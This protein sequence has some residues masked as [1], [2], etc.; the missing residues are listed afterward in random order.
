VKRWCKLAIAFAIVTFSACSEPVE[1][2]PDAAVYS[3]IVT[4]APNLTE[5]VFA[6][7]AGDAL[8]GV[9]AYSDY[10]PE[11]AS[12]P[13]VGDAFVIDQERLALLQ[14][15]LLLV[16]QSG[17][18]R[19]VVQE[20]RGLGY[21]VETLRTRSLDDV[22]AALR[23][24]GELTAHA[25]TARAAAA[26]FARTLQSIAV[27]NEGLERL[28]VFYQVSARPLYTING[29]HFVSQLIDLC[30]GDN[31]F[32]DLG[33]LAPAVDVEAVIARDPEV[34]LASTDAG[35]TA[36]DEWARW[37]KL[38]ANRYRNHFLMPADEIG[39][40]TPRLLDA[41]RAVCDALRAGREHRA[42]ATGD[43]Q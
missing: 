26:V 37:P 2:P 23:R 4:L 21:R 12:L 27:E 25:D 9:S 3:R 5:L 7:G 6:A 16:W 36:F 19:H 8:V 18:P 1:P 22:P 10:P 13:A 29:E 31:V 39:R 20:L 17:T 14:P 40:A 38:A 42:A 35:A 28:R 43:S 34:L 30:G 32:A 15:D 11:A 33:E 41:A 24:I